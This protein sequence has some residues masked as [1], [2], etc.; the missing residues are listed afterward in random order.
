[1]AQQAS[2]RAAPV[3]PEVLRLQKLLAQQMEQRAAAQVVC[4]TKG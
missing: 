4:V 2:K 1:M 3:S